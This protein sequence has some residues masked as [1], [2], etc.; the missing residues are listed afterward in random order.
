MIFVVVK[1]LR[2]IRSMLM[3]AIKLLF[4]DGE[5]RCRIS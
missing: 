4:E 5:N 1:Y 3:E 2:E